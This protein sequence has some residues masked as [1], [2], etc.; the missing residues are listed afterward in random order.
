MRLKSLL[1][2][3]IGVVAA[4][5]AQVTVTKTSGTNIINNGPVAIGSTETIAS[6]GTLISATGSLVDFRLGTLSLSGAGLYG[7]LAAGPNIT[8]TYSGNT[9]TISAAGEVGLVQSVSLSGGT[10]GLTFTLSNPTTFPSGTLSGI[11]IVANGGTGTS[12]PSLIAGNNVS[13]TGTWP[14]QTVSLSGTLFSASVSGQTPFSVTPSSTFSFAAGSNVTLTLSAGGVLTV[15]AIT[16]SGTVTQ[17]TGTTGRVGVTLSTST[18]VVTLPLM[19]LL[20]DTNE[21]INRFFSTTSQSNIAASIEGYT[22]PV[23]I[24]ATSY[25]SP[26]GYTGSDAAAGIYSGGV[27]NFLFANQTSSMQY[28]SGLNLQLSN[29]IQ[30]GST[31]AIIVLGDSIGNYTMQHL[32]NPL[33]KA[34]GYVGTNLN[35]EWGG[36]PG[37]LGAV[38][39]LGGATSSNPISGTFTYS[40]DGHWDNIPAGGSAAY[41][42]E[43]NVTPW[44]NRWT[45]KIPLE[46]GLGNYTIQT[47]STSWAGPFSDVTGTVSYTTDGTNW[48]ST[49]AGVI[50]NATASAS[51][52]IRLIRVSSATVSQ[53]WVRV[54]GVSGQVISLV[55]DFDIT[56]VPGFAVYRYD[57]PSIA[58]ENQTSV[59]AGRAAVMFNAENPSMVSMAYVDGAGNQFGNALTSTSTVFGAWK[60]LAIAGPPIGS[61]GM[62]LVGGNDIALQNAAMGAWATQTGNYYFDGYTMAKSYA[63]MRALDPTY[64]IHPNDLYSRFA[65]TLL[66][67]QLGLFNYSGGPLTAA[68]LSATKVAT[69]GPIYFASGLGNTAG[70][71]LPVNTNYDVELLSGASNSFTISYGAT[72]GAATVSFSAGPAFR[73]VDNGTTGTISFGSGRFSTFG[74]ATQSTISIVTS[75][76]SGGGA[77]FFGIAD[78]ANGSGYVMVQPTDQG[79]NQYITLDQ[80]NKKIKIISA[81]SSGTEWIGAVNDGGNSY[82]TTFRT[83]SLSNSQINYFQFKGYNAANSEI[84]M[85]D[86]RPASATFSGSVSATGIISTGTNTFSGLT[87]FTNTTQATSSTAASVTLAGGLGVTKTAIFG[88]NLIIPAAAFSGSTFTRGLIGAGFASTDTTSALYYGIARD[89]GGGPDNT[90]FNGMLLQ[91]YNPG[92]G[93]SSKIQFWIDGSGDF[94]STNMVEITKNRLTVTGSISATD[95]ISAAGLRATSATSGIGYGAGS[96]GTVTQSTDRTTGVTINKVSGKIV[97]AS[98]SLAALAAATFV[99]TNSA[100]AATDVIVLNK[101]SGWINEKTDVRTLSVSAGSFSIT[102]QDLDA[103][104]AETGTGSINFVVIKG[105][106]N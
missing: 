99:V 106:T 88:S 48:T 98:N 87:A 91:N 40:P 56:G 16:N 102:V 85:L 42:G 33:Q 37:F 80:P 36:A 96:G 69:S 83:G 54:V 63:N 23:T 94:A 11:L 81:N 93:S 57:K 32:Y 97:T 10:T 75:T 45:F 78:R 18:P 84:T 67:Q 43:F 65:G 46:P 3:F 22:Y 2:G 66:N 60:Y 58:L 38:Y 76:I 21:Y 82:V 74:T 50:V 19:L 25:A 8:L 28:L 92:P 12:S 5:S 86:L 26:F 27:S 13:I 79:F 90:R 71:W 53:T 31:S 55:P 101:S 30:Y 77:A 61:G 51:A 62:P 104:T 100:V 24:G 89:G 70:G 17:V 68:T 14:N 6:G 44:A 15:N 29:V 52:G 20:S 41:P 35:S 59:Q 7:S 49:N 95:T 1:L 9:V 4:L 34:Y 39:L 105:S 73:V 64:D 103:V 47:S 72:A